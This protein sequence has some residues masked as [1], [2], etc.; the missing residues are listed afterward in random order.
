MNR[1]ISI[2]IVLIMLWPHYT[3]AQKDEAVISAKKLSRDAFQLYY[4]KDFET[5]FAKYKAAFELDPNRP[6]NEYYNAACCAS[7]LNEN[8]MAHLFLKS[9]IERGYLS[10]EYIVENSQFSNLSKSEYW[11]RTIAL[12]DEKIDV[13]KSN[14]KSLEDIDIRDFVPFRRGELW[15]YLYSKNREVIVEPTYTRTYLGGSCLLVEV[16]PKNF[17]SIHPDRTFSVID[18]ISKRPYDTKQYYD[19]IYQ[20]AEPY[21]DKNFKGFKHDGLGKITHLSMMYAKPNPT[22]SGFVDSDIVM[23][24]DFVNPISGIKHLGPFLVDKTW[25]A[26]VKFNNSWGVIN[27]EGVVLDHI[28]FKYRTL[29]HLSECE[30]PGSWFYFVDNDRNKGFINAKGEIRFYNEFDNNPFQYI[31]KMNMFIAKK[32]DVNGVIDLSR[33]EWVIEPI[34]LKIEKVEYSYQGDFHGDCISYLR[35][36]EREKVKTFYFLVK[37]VLGNEFYIDEE[38]KIFK[39]N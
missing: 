18:L 17:I 2:G 7:M 10:K 4:K 25:H 1:I 13:L 31:Y 23:E 9:S 11:E 33:L 35:H 12:I 27:E 3:M 14:F 39:E 24:E 29:V 30:A 8:K 36:E 16:I 22:S 34:K 26:I 21:T 20:F 15:G 6:K 37:D 32:G 38:G 5:C 19:H 28:P